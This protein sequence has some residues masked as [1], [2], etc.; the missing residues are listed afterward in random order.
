MHHLVQIVWSTLY[1]ATVPQ[2]TPRRQNAPTLFENRKTE[3]EGLLAFLVGRPTKPFAGLHNRST[4]SSYLVYPRTALADSRHSWG[5]VHKAANNPL[6]LHKTVL[7]ADTFVRDHQ[8]RSRWW[9]EN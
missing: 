9:P 6:H 8:D 7:L 4:Y 3:P 2:G 1:I 5:T